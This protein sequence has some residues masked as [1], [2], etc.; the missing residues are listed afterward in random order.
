MPNSVS[1]CLYLTALIASLYSG[2]DDEPVSSDSGVND[3]DDG[4][5]LSCEEADRILVT[6][7][8]ISPEL[9][10]LKL[11]KADDECSTW[12]PALECKEKAS[13]LSSCEQP[14]LAGAKTGAGE[15][16]SQISTM[17][18]PRITPGCFGGPSCPPYHAVRCESGICVIVSN[19]D[20]GL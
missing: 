16:L 9:Q 1:R 11:C 14:I 10:K 20:A 2:C 7:L 6:E 4:G 15:W 19:P 3:I 13:E 18:C 8:Q 17:I 12:L 5:L